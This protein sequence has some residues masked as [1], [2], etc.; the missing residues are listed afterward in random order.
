MVGVLG[1]DGQALPFGELMREGAAGGGEVFDPLARLRDLLP[2]GQ[3]ELVALRAGGGLG[4]GRAQRR[5][6]LFGVAAA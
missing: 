6:V 5:V 4:F 3:G 1:R 2:W